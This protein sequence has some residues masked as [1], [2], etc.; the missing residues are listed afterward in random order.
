M[1]SERDHRIEVVRLDCLQREQCLAGI[2]DGLGDHE[3]DASLGGPPDLLGEYVA[4]GVM[5]RGIVRVVDVGVADIAGHQGVV[6]GADLLGDTQRLPVQWLEVALAADY[7]QLLAVGVVGECLNHVRSGMYVFPVQP[8]HH[9][10]LLEHHLWHE[11]P[12]LQVAAPLELEQI[13]LGANHWPGGKAIEKLTH[14]RH[15]QGP[16]VGTTVPGKFRRRDASMKSSAQVVVIGGGVVGASVLF[17]LTELGWTDVVLVERKELTAGST[18][19]AAG[20]MHT[21]NGDPNVAKLQQYTVGLYQEIEQRSGRNCG[22]HM[23]GGLTLAGDRER[24]DWLRMAQARGRYLGIDMEIISPA[25]AK[26][27]FP[28]LEE[29]YFVGALFDPAEGH[30]DP[31]GVTW[32]YAGCARQAGA[33]IYQHTW[34]SDLRQRPDGTWDVITDGGEIHAEHIVNAGGLWA[35]EVGRMIGLELPVLAMEHMYLITEDMHEVAEHNAATG[36]ELPMGLDFD[37]EIYIRQEGGAMLL[38]TYEQACVPWSPRETPWTFDKQ[39]LTPDLDRI[40]PSLEIAFKHYPAMAE[41]GIKNVINGPFTFAPDG[42]PLVG[43]VPGVR[44]CWV[45]CAVMAGFSQGGGVGLPLARWMVD[46]DPGEDI[47][48]MDVARYGDWASLAY[49]NAKVRENYSRRFRIRFPNEELPAAPPLRTTP[50][51]EGLAAAP[52]VFG[53]YCA[54]EHAL[55]F[56]PSAAEASEEITFHRS[57]AHAHAGTECRAVAEAVGLLEISNYGKFEVTGAGA[58]A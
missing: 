51:Y 46:G 24:M 52:A 20:G 31:T 1:N 39:L 54:L 8:G 57:G 22:I 38:G 55:W 12:G 4:D 42:N 16:I 11:R 29:Q 15:L 14:A 26:Q 7:R 6:L 47:W 13:P 45:A 53:D 2:V 17:H 34:V 41:A 36:H 30:V 21:L 37:G 35:R 3:V 33:E 58:E 9:V 10:G 23:S 19:H 40:A 27:L 25:E 56:A 5:R 32:A 48:A 18:W 28:L 44:N 50:V 49:T 43:P